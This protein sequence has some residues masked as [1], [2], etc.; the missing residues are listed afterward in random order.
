MMFWL[1]LGGLISWVYLSIRPPRS[2]VCGSPNGP[3]VTAP[4]VRL[5]DGRHL[6]YQEVGVPKEKAQYKVIAVHGYGGSRHECFPVSEALMKELGVYLVSF[7]RA[8]YGQSDPFPQRTVKSDALDIQDLADQLD[9]GKRFYLVS[10]SIGGYSAWGCLKYLPHRL[11]GV[12]MVAPVTNFWWPGIPPKEARE[13]FQTQGAG[14]RMALRV[15]HYAPWLVYWWMNQKWFP[16]S[17]TVEGSPTRENE[18]DRSIRAKRA[19]EIDPL[20]KQEASQQGVFECMHRDMITEFG[21]WEFDPGN[22]ENPFKNGNG[23][24]HIW[25]G[26][27]DYLVPVKLQRYIHRRL[28]WI[29]YHELPGM[30]HVLVRVK[31]L[32]DRILQAL[33]LGEEKQSISSYT[34]L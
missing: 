34:K 33:L 23:S 5:R 14:D 17:S 11:A 6:A 18:L 28:P 30:G 10:N 3:P 9:L 32:P 7:D 31:G 12:A 26:V 8:G 29:H 1:I 4:R 13:A 19:V 24:V 2:K 21:T 15:S 27:E 20:V 25:Q 16:T 22:L